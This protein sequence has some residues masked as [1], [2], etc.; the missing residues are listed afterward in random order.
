MAAKVNP[1]P[2][3]TSEIAEVVTGFSGELK[4]LPNI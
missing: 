1:K 2:S 4:I 3:Q